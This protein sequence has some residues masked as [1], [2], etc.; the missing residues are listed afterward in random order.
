M[1]VVGGGL[2][3][4]GTATAH[5]EERGTGKWWRAFRANG[6]FFSSFLEW[7][8]FFFGKTGGKNDVIGA[9]LFLPGPYMLPTSTSLVLLLLLLLLLLL[10]A[11]VALGASAAPVPSSAMGLDRI[12]MQAATVCVFND[13]GTSHVPVRR[14]HYL[15]VDTYVH[16]LQ[17]VSLGEYR[18]GR[19][20]MEGTFGQVPCRATVAMWTVADNGTRL[21]ASWDW[22]VDGGGGI[23]RTSRSIGEYHTVVDAWLVDGVAGGLYDDND[24]HEHEHEEGGDVALLYIRLSED[25]FLDILRLTPPQPTVQP[26]E[27]SSSAAGFFHGS[28]YFFG[29][30]TVGTNGSSSSSSSS[31]AFMDSSELHVSNIPALFPSL[32]MAFE[33]N[34]QGHFADVN[35][36]LVLPS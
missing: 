11:T 34:Q 30:A 6:M 10:P 22:H 2:G 19:L 18:T 1:V 20:L 29:S 9:T 26:N 24:E 15:A 35:T 28:L 14:T 23:H 4:R 33:C 12:P 16:L 27:A 8:D 32:R 25:V 36:I 21:L 5:K 7:R 17:G 31:N 13:V 3:V